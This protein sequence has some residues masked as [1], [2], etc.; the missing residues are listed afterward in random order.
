MDRDR[1]DYNSADGWRAS[2]ENAVDKTEYDLDTLKRL[3]DR[4]QKNSP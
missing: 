4:W 1:D 2:V 3:L